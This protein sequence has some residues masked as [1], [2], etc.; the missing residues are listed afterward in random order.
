MIV[1][2]LLDTCV[3]SELAKTRPVQSVVDWVV[4]Q[5][6]SRCF[7][8][9]ITLGEIQKG[10]SKLADTPKKA[11]LQA[12]LDHDVRERFV[13]KIIAIAANEVLQWGRM[14]AALEQQGRPMPLMDSLIAATAL[15]HDMT[16]VTRNTRDVEASGVKL[17]NP[18]G[19]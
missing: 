3:V 2:Y 15:F 9:S 10:V 18:W 8:S 4:S 14:Q 17:L 5:D 11:E 12:W 19:M 6:A 13:G 16:L 1:N 7:I